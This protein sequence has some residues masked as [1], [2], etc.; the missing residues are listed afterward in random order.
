MVFH[1][2]VENESASAGGGAFV[3]SYFNAFVLRA[4]P[5]MSAR[6]DLCIGTGG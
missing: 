6:V 4:W 5:A 1:K 2:L 3:T